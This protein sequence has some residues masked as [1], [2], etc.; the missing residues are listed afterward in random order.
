MNEEQFY[1][2]DG[3]LLR[4]S[5]LE[6]LTEVVI[7]SNVKVIAPRVFANS[8]IRTLIL[9]EGLEAISDEAFYKCTRLKEIVIP[10]TVKYIGKLAFFNCRGGQKYSNWQGC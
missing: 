10:D 3:T 8:Q 6:K 5:N 1:I 9:N 2:E 4:V 7:P